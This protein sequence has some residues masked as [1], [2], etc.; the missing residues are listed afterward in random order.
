MLNVSFIN[1]LQYDLNV[2]RIAIS[3]AL[4]NDVWYI[5]FKNTGNNL[6]EVV[7]RKYYIKLFYDTDGAW[8]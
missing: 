8:F 3:N 4:W 5:Q 2:C 6:Y 7:K 1:R